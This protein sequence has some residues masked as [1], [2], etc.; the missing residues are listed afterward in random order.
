MDSFNS[1]LDA[2]LKQRAR[3]LGR[4]TA[5][6]R[7]E[8]PPESDG[9]YH[10]ANIRGN[11]LIIMTDSPVWTTRIRQLGPRI[12]T[13]LHNSG[14][15]KLMHIRVFSRPGRSATI[16]P[17]PPKTKPK[18]LSPRSGQ[19]ISQ[20]ASFIDDDGLRDA[21]LKLARRATVKREPTDKE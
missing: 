6:L 15:T 21:L 12:L 19:L 14:S 16:Q 17:R 2:S 9:H 3:E 7:S 1:R 8:L 11:T 5:L 13:V 4:L 20:T 18:H 10:V